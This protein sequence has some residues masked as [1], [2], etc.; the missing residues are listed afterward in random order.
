MYIVLV[1]LNLHL[2]VYKLSLITTNIPLAGQP[3]LYKCITLVS[4][5]FKH[6]RDPRA[7]RW[8]KMHE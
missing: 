3:V 8:N 1:R 4:I 5:S 2:T 6:I 7:A